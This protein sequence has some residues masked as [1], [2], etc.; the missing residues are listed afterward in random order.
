[1]PR[2]EGP[3]CYVC[4]DLYVPRPRWRGGGLHQVWVKGW[5]Y[6]T[7]IDKA[8]NEVPDKRLHLND[9]APDEA[10]WF[11]EFADNSHKSWHEKH[12]DGNAVHLE[13]L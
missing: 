1:M 6:S 11:Y 8:G 5:H 9:S 12:G 10:N 13:A 7:R 2:Y 3:V 4:Q